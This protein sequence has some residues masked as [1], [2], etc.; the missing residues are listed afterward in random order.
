M[1]RDYFTLTVDG[2]AGERVERPIVTITYEGPAEQIESR[3]RKGSALLEA[4]DVDVAY[5][6]QDSLEDDS[7]R[8]VVALADR[9]TGEYVFEL[10]ADAKDIF[11]FIDAAREFGENDDDEGRYRIVLETDAGHL[12]TYDKSTLLV[13][14]AEGDLL[15]GKSLLPSG[16]E[17]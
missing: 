6:L 2:V 13:Y 16:V 7:P 17:L 4:E 9:I 14:D 15:R 12:A 11:A 3:L 5:R 1:R 8:G 10:N